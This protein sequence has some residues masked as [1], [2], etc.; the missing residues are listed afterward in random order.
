MKKRSVKILT[1]WQKVQLGRKTKRMYEESVG[2]RW[3]RCGV[4]SQRIR[5]YTDG[6]GR[7]LTG[8]EK[9]YRRTCEDSILHSDL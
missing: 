7:F 4:E 2:P 6:G 8:E 3:T 9:R 5:P 1:Q